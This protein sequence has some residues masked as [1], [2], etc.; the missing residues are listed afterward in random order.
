M[1]DLIIDSHCHYGPG[2]GF[3]GPWDTRA[4]VKK[5]LS[6]S[7]EAGIHK[8]VFFAAFHSDYSKANEE[9]ARFVNR[10]PE[11]FL[12]YV[13]VHADRDKGR[14]FRMVS[15]AVNEYQFKG[16]KVHRADARISREICEV[17]RHFSLPVLY[18]VLGEVSA[19]ELLATEFGDVNFI[20]PHLGSFADDW[21]AQLMFIDFLVRHPNIYTDTSGVKR[22]DLLEMAFKRAGAHKILFGTDGPWLHPGLELAKIFALKPTPYEQELMLGK[23]FLKL[24]SK[25]KTN[26]LQSATLT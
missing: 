22:F 1:N 16:I 25:V 2:D 15:Q 9:V 6:W 8:I 13:F 23:N 5:F 3:N 17:A 24:I 7:R 10:F 12:G 4:S 11:K 20:I 21:K 18:D 14:I 26:A 19:V